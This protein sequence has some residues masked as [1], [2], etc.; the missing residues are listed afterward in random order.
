M[1]KQQL[2]EIALR[3]IQKRRADALDKNEQTLAALRTHADFAANEKALRLATVAKVMSGTHAQ[4]AAA[5]RDVARLLAEQKKLLQ[6]YNCN[7]KTLTPTFFC[8]KC[9]D[10]GYVDGLPCEC[11]QREIRRLLVA[12]C[13]VP[14]PEFTFS[15]STEKDKQNLAVYRRAQ[16][17]C[18]EPHGN[19]LLFGKVGTG[20]TYLLTACANK[21]VE[22]GKTVVFVTAY[23]LNQSFLEAHLSNLSQKEQILDRLSDV[24]VLVIDDLGTEQTYKNVTQEY[25]FAILNERLTNGKQ[26]FISTNLSLADI[27]DK[28][29]NRIF[30]RLIRQDKDNL[31]SMLS[32]KD[33]R[34][35]K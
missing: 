28:Y 10:T 17:I 31:I 27:K 9:S 8:D 4:T 15:A 6:K 32:S 33:K 1:T 18:A 23:G 13:A 35:E 16:Q 34:L 30:S 3:N 11:L 29:D 21:C 7:E 24:D 20:K 14:H 19:I 2:T 22:L 12:D 5:Q 26:T 25:L